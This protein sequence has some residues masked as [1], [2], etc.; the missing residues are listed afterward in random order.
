MRFTIV[1]FLYLILPAVSSAQVTGGYEDYKTLGSDYVNCLV[2]NDTTALYEKIIDKKF[3]MRML[4]CASKE[5]DSAAMMLDSLA[6]KNYH[7]VF[8]V[9]YR[10][11]FNKMQEEL[12][13]ENVSAPTIDS[14]DLTKLSTDYAI[15][16]GITDYYDLNIYLNSND[17]KYGIQ[18]EVTQYL[19][20]W[21][22]IDIRDPL[23]GAGLG[24]KEDKKTQ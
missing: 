16:K 24:N 11:Y 19:G 2:K 23:I 6:N 15:C 10:R 8:N 9:C 4:D 18:I 20:M 17:R 13:K 12:Q 21:Y 7:K 3:F 22:A 14:L 1:L 5:G